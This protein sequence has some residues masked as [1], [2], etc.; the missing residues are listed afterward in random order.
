MGDIDGRSGS[1]NERR[2]I[3]AVRCNE[4]DLGYALAREIVEMFDNGLEI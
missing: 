3:G 2:G 1:T 4:Y